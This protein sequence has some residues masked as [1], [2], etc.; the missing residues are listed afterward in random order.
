MGECAVS[1]QAEWLRELDTKHRLSGDW[2]WVVA[3]VQF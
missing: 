1:L 2:V 3:G